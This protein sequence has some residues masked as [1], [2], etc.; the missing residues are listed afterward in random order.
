[1]KRDISVQ[2]SGTLSLVSKMQESAAKRLVFASNA[3]RNT[4][5]LP[6]RGAEHS[7]L[8]QDFLEAINVGDSRANHPEAQ[9]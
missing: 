4:R 2:A 1:M 5:E 6:K 8:L 7:A 9:I 3:P